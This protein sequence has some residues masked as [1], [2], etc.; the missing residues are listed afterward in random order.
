MVRNVSFLLNILSDNSTQHVLKRSLTR[1]QRNNFMSSKTSWWHVLKMS[2][3]H[4]LKCFED[5]SWRRL[6]DIMRHYRDKE[7]TYWR[8]LY[9]TNINVYLTNLYFTNLY[10]TILRRIQNALIRTCRKW[11]KF[12]INFRGKTRK[13]TV[14]FLTFTEVINYL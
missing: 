6:E 1:L 3:R 5:M 4:V 7:I 11:L 8:Y 14:H 12:Y 9:L 2:W 10:L 13:T